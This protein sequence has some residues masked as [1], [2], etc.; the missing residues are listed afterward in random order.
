MGQYKSKSLNLISKILIM[1]ESLLKAEAYFS[2]S[3]SKKRT[4]TWILDLRK[5]DS[6]KNRPLEKPDRKA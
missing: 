4:R 5:N 2:T 1:T 6:I 3:S